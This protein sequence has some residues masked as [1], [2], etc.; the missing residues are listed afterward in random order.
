MIHLFTSLIKFKSA[1][2]VF[3]IVAAGS[4]FAGDLTSDSIP[5]DELRS[6]EFCLTD[7]GNTNVNSMAA[8]ASSILH[9]NEAISLPYL[10]KAVA[11]NPE[12]ASLVKHLISRINKSKDKKIYSE[13][14]IKMAQRDP[15][16]LRLS[17]SAIIMLSREKKRKE[18]MDLA[19]Q[20]YQA[21]RDKDIPPQSKPMFISLIRLIGAFRLEEKQY[22]EAVKLYRGIMDNSRYGN[23]PTLLEGAALVF[24]KAAKFADTEN[25]LWIFNSD[26][27]NLEDARDDVIEKLADM[28]AEK[29]NPAACNALYTLYKSLGRRD[30]AYSI[31]LKRLTHQP[32]SKLL[33]KLLALTCFRN[34]EYQL[35]YS[36]WQALAGMRELMAADYMMF[37]EAAWKSGHD[38]F[39]EIIFSRYINKYPR[40]IKAKLMLAMLLYDGGKTDQ[41][42][43]LLEKLPPTTIS[44]HLKSLI[45]MKQHKYSEALGYMQQIEKIYSKRKARMSP[46]MYVSM[47]YLAEKTGN[48]ALFEKYIKDMYKLEPERKAEWDNSI[49]YV[50]ADHNM[51]LTEAEKLIRAALAD[52]KGK[53]EYL[54]SL[55]WVLYHQ[56]RYKEARK[57]IDLAISGQHNVPDA[58]IADHAG[59]IY[60]SLGD[61]N[62]ALKYWHL[63]LK[64]Y[65]TELTPG[66][67]KAKIN[68]VKM[69]QAGTPAP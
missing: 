68:K 23:N 45:V 7:S 57:Y 47:S 10:F 26:R 66:L 14:L 60:Y 65:G 64:I 32:N 58:V 20:T 38:G 9:D 61:H 69:N 59:D 5:E 27:E 51:R 30:Q 11:A 44:L 53:P 2:A 18:A 19:I 48:V 12:S 41:A 52:K 17:L 28:N 62:S 22:S 33:R 29:Y 1:L 49:G 16:A 15:S 36:T 46:Y 34:K 21:L 43:K 67:I 31:L 40:S 13:Q 3:L 37:G 24:D 50:L 6:L 4:L 55:A 63:A 56:K 42:S 54:D 39:A 8:F 35:S 25:F